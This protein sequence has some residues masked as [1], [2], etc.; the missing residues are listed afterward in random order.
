[1]KK[2]QK[3]SSQRGENFCVQIWKN[4]WIQ[5][6]FILLKKQSRKVRTYTK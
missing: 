5:T 1:V 3:I 2:K 4:W 6:F